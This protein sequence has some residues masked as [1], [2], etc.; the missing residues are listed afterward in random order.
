MQGRPSDTNPPGSGPRGTGMAGTWLAASRTVALLRIDA[1]GTLTPANPAAA[2]LI[3]RLPC[4]DRRTATADACFTEPD[5]RRIRLWLERGEGPQSQPVLLNVVD[6]DG[7]PAS[8]RSWLE[9][10]DGGLWMIAEPTAGGDPHREDEWL[11]LNNELAALARESARRG[12]ELRR[13][14]DDLERSY[15]LIRKVHEVLPI[16]MEC[17]R[18]KG[19]ETGWQDVVDFLRQHSRFLSHGYCP[20]CTEKVMKALEDD[21]A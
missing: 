5:A 19:D 6:A 15:W 7:A 16:C 4:D 14:L 20:E 18:V 11:R 17:G 1:E 8:Y 13:T 10:C 9:P 12:R 2:E 3:A 21:H